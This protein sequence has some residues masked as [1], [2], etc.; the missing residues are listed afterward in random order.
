[1]GLRGIASLAFVFCLAPLRTN[2]L[3]TMLPVSNFTFADVNA[4]SDS[5]QGPGDAN[6]ESYVEENGPHQFGG[7]YKWFASAAAGP[8]VVNQVGVDLTRPLCCVLGASS[9]IANSDWVVTNDTDQPLEGLRSGVVIP[10]GEI[11][12]RLPP[13]V[14]PQAGDNVGS[15]LVKVFTE[16][17]A[18][19]FEYALRLVTTDGGFE[20]V[21]GS[22]GNVPIDLIHNGQGG[23]WGYTLAAVDV[24]FTLPTVPAHGQ[25]TLHHVMQVFGSNDFLDGELG[26]GLS[27]KLGD[28]LKPLSGSSLYLVP[29]PSALVLLGLG[30][31]ALA[32][33]RA[34]HGATVAALLALL[35]LLGAGQA[36]AQACGLVEDVPSEFLDDFVGTLGGLFPLS[37][38][39]C[40]KITKSAVSTCHKAVSGSADC[41]ENQIKSARKGAK[42]GCAARGAGEDACN[43]DI[44]GFLDGL[45]A[46]LEGKADGAHAECDGSF[47]SQLDLKCREGIE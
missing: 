26:A 34:R 27:V 18:V 21:A 36:R 8:G 42:T 33:R 29:E 22:T 12:F 20:E 24:D 38:A 2:A 41:A 47:A 37:A 40:E 32:A 46:V 1:M 45:E 35:T 39:D 23:L 14:P 5:D 15:V 44:G 13:N 16:T 10:A 17:N 9:A 19:L 11:L 43:A 31:A 30:L 6:V 4:T 25:I 3:P 28:P 7:P